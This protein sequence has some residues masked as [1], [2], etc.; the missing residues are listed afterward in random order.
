MVHQYRRSVTSIPAN[1]LE[2][3]GEWRPGKR[4]H[5]F[6]I[7]KGSMWESWAHTDSFV[8]FELASPD[9]ITEV[10]DFQRQMTALLI[11]S[12][13]NLE[14]EGVKEELPFRIKI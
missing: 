9:A 3:M 10:R 6:S 13:R 12:I 8:D 2:A 4:L 1:V 5:Y 7:A 14:A 11:T